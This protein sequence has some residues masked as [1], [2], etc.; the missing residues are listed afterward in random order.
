VHKR[1]PLNSIVSQLSLV[2]TFTICFSSIHFEI[3]LLNGCKVRRK[4]GHEG[5]EVE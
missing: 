4:T 3:G 2:H 5:P 1:D